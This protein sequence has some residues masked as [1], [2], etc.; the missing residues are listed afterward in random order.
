MA[1]PNVEELAKKK[2]V[3]GLIRA[4]KYRPMGKLFTEDIR[5]KAARALGGLGNPRAIRPLRQSFSDDLV[6]GSAAVA[7]LAILNQLSEEDYRKNIK[8]LFKAF[9]ISL[10][11]EEEKGLARVF[12]MVG[13]PV[14]ESLFK[15]CAYLSAGGPTLE[16]K[17][18]QAALALGKIGDKRAVKPL[19]IM[20]NNKY[21]G[22]RGEAAELLGQ[23][24]DTQA[25]ETLSR[26]MRTATADYI[27]C[28]SM[29][30]ALEKMGTPGLEALVQAL[31]S[32]HEWA[33]LCAAKV[34]EEVELQQ[35]IAMTERDRRKLE[36]LIAE[37]E[38]GRQ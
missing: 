12:A 28:S 37:L 21:C 13:K 15:Y 29:A 26:A 10:D 19:M 22:D 11:R 36:A 25:V 7:I 32:R 14:A 30:K 27:T 33:P 38:A 9:E 17:G 5:R 31:H 35:K 2:D 24:G 34:I 23:L 18:E 3:A 6:S 8:S 1:E 20:V 16:H 4:L